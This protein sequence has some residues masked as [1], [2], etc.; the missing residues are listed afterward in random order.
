MCGCKLTKTAPHCDGKTCA[1]MLKEFENPTPEKP[2][3]IRDQ[4]KRGDTAT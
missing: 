4:L 3:K 2:K 1:C